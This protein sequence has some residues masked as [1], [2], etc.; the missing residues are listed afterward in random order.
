MGVV[1]PRTTGFTLIEMIVSLAIFSLVVTMSIG[2]LL[3]LISGNQKLQGEQ[4]V[5]TN[6]SFAIDSMTREIRTGYSYICAAVSNVNIGVDFGSG[7]N[8]KVFKESGPGSDD[9]DSLDETWIRDCSAVGPGASDLT[10]T[11][12]GVS[13]M[14][15]GDSITGA[16][17]TRI[18]Y[19]FNQDAEEIRRRVGNAPSESLLSSGLEVLDAQF[20]VTGSQP[21]DTQQP[22]VLV[23]VRAKEVGADKEYVIQ[24]SV[25]QRILDLGL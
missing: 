11:L 3:V 16:S 2:S 14:E 7:P 19:Y 24:T 17:S 25:T 18:M 23:Y 1:T 5:M 22:T 20:I 4:S 15:G 8:E 9:H 21:G 12:R 10:E 13:F 6:L